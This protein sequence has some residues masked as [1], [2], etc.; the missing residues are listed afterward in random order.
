MA[1]NIK[2]SLSSEHNHKDKAE[3]HEAAAVHHAKLKKMH[4]TVASDQD[5]KGQKNLAVIHRKMAAHHDALSRHHLVLNAEHK[6]RAA[7]KAAAT[8]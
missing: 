7:K 5:K 1:T 4:N 3:K 6:R 2:V 8:E